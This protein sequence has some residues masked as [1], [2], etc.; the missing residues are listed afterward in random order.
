MKIN[1]KVR[2]KNPYFWIGL[3]GVIMA[4]LGVRLEDFTSWSMVLEEIKNVAGNPF[5]FISVILAVIGVVADPT[6]K[7]VC[8]SKQALGYSKPRDDEVNYHDSDFTK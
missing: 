6:T 1:W 4:T 5:L 2:F 3:V 7:G 8:D